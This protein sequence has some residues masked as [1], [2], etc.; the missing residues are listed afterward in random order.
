M[1]PRPAPASARR[2][3]WHC[4]QRIERDGAY[5]NLVLRTELATAGLA[6]R[7]RGFVTELVAGTTRMRRACDAVLDRFVLTEP[8]PE[9]RTLLRL[10]AYQ[11]VFAGVAPH[12]A[13]GETVELAPKR[14]RGFV[15]AILRNVAR[16]PM[17]WPSA[18]VELSYTDWMFDRLV[19][20]LG[21]EA[22]LSW[23]RGASDAGALVAAICLGWI[24]VL[25]SKPSSRPC[26]QA[27]RKPVSSARSR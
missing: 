27:A 22:V 17:V 13:V 7:D 19:A 21:D 24:R 4:L 15:N 3:A 10:G 12:A 9:I 18:A 1:A 16:T 5:S 2:V 23:L 6:E 25:P 11:L 26:W 14:A 20:E 8:E